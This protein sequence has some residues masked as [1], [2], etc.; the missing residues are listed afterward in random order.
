MEKENVEKEIKDSADVPLDK[1]IQDSGEV[2][3]EELQEVQKTAQNYWDQLLR[4]QADFAN[5]RKR[6]EKEK[7]EAIRLG[8]VLMIEKMISLLDIMEEAL[9]HAHSSTDNATLKQG[10]EMVI[11]EFSNFLK[12]EGT[13][14]LTT[15]GNLFDPHLHEAVEQTE[16]EEEDKNNT[17]LSEIQKG[18]TLNGQLLRPAKVKVAK[19]KPKEDKEKN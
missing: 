9:K 5:Y 11:K 1:T 15:V 4:L 19:L 14:P 6:S 18:Y 16:T 10:F 17:V 2:V 12:S 13:L 3:Q 8:K 7:L